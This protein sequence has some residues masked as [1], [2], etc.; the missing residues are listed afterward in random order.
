MQLDICVGYICRFDL[1]RPGR[2]FSRSNAS[3]PPPPLPWAWCVCARWGVS[4][5]VRVDVGRAARESIV[6]APPFEALHV[7]HL[8]TL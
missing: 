5:G 2:N 8:V 1:R 7:A 3:P 4:R 6:L